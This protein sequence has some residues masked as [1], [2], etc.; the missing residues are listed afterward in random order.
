[1]NKWQAEHNFKFAILRGI[2]A[3]GLAA[4]TI[5]SF[6]G[7]V[8]AQSLLDKIKNGE[9]IRLGFA[10]DPPSAYPGE[11]NAPLGFVNA[12]TLDILKKL[13]TTKSNQS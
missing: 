5:S 12:M 10:S 11:N 2:A 13:G 9:T 4:T 6:A 7:S 1:M 3:L 8:S